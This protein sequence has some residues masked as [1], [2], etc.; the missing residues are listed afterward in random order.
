MD[1]RE[2]EGRESSVWADRGLGEGRLAFRNFITEVI[3]KMV[4]EDQ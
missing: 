4:S 2:R 3:M 1:T